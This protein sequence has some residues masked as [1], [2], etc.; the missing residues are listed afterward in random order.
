M[1]SSTV[2]TVRVI[3]SAVDCPDIPLVVDGGNAKVVVWPGNGA[4]HRTFQLLRLDAGGKTILLE[5]PSD[6]VYYVVSGSGA[7]FD[8]ETGAP[9][10]LG[11]GS[12]IHVDAGSAYRFQ[13]DAASHMTIL[14]GPCPADERLYANLKAG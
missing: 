11:E 10:P 6:A 12:M 9:Q 2:E 1:S 3:D 8:T 13:A 5:H 14:G 4:R 7:V